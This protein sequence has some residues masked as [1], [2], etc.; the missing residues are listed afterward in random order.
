[1]P[2]YVV[3]G[4]DKPSLRSTNKMCKINSLIDRLVAVVRFLT[5]SIDHQHSR[6]AQIVEFC[7][8]DGL[9]I[10]NICQVCIIRSQPVAQ[11]RQVVMHYLEGHDM[12]VANPKRFMGT[13][14]V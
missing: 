10:R 8:I 3:T 14:F 4:M 7:R 1:M 12:N 5:K 2:A 6:S 9:H 11:D 13:D